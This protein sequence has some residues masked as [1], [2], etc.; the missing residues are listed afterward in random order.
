MNSAP[1]LSGYFKA[2]AASKN[3]MAATLRPQDW[4]WLLCV[5]DF[6]HSGGM[7]PKFV[8]PMY[9]KSQRPFKADKDRLVMLGLV[10]GTAEGK[11]IL[12]TTGLGLL[13]DV[14]KEILDAMKD[15]RDRELTARRAHYGDGIEG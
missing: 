7:N 8:N 1:I 2:I 11:Y 5:Y 9:R 3:K 14:N 12:S 6:Q 15:T 10:L 4:F 13:A